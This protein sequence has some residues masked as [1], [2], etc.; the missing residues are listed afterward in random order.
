MSRATTRQKIL[1]ISKSR[2]ALTR[3]LWAQPLGASEKTFPARRILHARTFQF[4]SAHRVERIGI[5][6]AHGGFY[7]SE[8]PPDDW[9]TS[10]RVLNWNGRKWEEIAHRTGLR[11]PQD[12]RTIW[13]ETGAFVSRGLSLEIRATG[14]DAGWSGWDMAEKSFVVEARPV[15]ADIA[16]DT[17]LRLAALDFKG[18]PR[19]LSAEHLP[20]EIRFRSKWLE[21]GFS[22]ARTGFSYLSVDGSGKGRTHADLIRRDS[23][24][25]DYLHEQGYG[26]TM[27]LH[28]NVSGLRLHP[29]G[30][31][32]E[33]GFTAHRVQGTT[34]VT[35]N[36]VS[37]D[38]TCAGSGVRY[39]IEWTVFSD[40]LEADMRRS[41]ERPVRAWHSS[42]W[43]IPLN[44]ATAIP[45][46]LGAI[47]RE[48]EAGGMK[49]PTLLHF[50][51]MGTLRAEA[52]SGGDDVLWRSDV[53]RNRTLATAEIKL[54]ESPM[55]EG[56]YLLRAGDHRARM[57]FSLHEHRMSLKPG[58]PAVVRRAAQNAALSAVT[59]RGDVGALANNGASLHCII[60]ADLWP[61]VGEQVGKLLPG[62]HA[63]D[64]VRHSFQ[65]FLDGGLSVGGG[66]IWTR[67]GFG[68]LRTRL[69]RA[70][71]LFFWDWRGSSRQLLMRRSFL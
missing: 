51:S 62:L 37:Y 40:R 21:V 65:R 7:G 47:T 12:G 49:G 14:V 31:P 23:R 41:H 52:V 56:D 16:P 71:R 13:L 2:V 68:S 5:V 46:V 30:V 36:R 44:L 35:G 50:P 8:Q 11:R 28:Y 38:V 70:V 10:L 39:R 3:A 25:W 19:G 6:R 20:G 34:R 53:W 69:S 27:N 60:C 43:H 57:V 63:R 26:G 67:T 42:L 58:T 9:I 55:P 4:E 48:G 29:V 45:T 18:L 54:A 64:L 33:I 24:Q 22:L 59:W 61:E 66:G 1:N 32:A 17:S 15:T